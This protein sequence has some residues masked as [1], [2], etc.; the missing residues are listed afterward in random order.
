MGES[1][2]SLTSEAQQLLELASSAEPDEEQMFQDTLEGLLAV[3][4][5]K[6]DDYC[7]VMDS[8]EGKA[9]IV[10]K[11]INRLKAIEDR[12]TSAHKRMESALKGS[13]EALNR[14]TIETDLHTIKLV[15]NGG[16]E[17]LN[18]NEIDVPEEYMKKEIKM[19]PDKDKIRKALK[20]GQ[21]L[22]FASLGNRGTH[23]KIS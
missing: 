3:I 20:A 1:L 23:I 2:F 19:S 13:M 9:N 22:S 11:E 8:I 4:D 17:P 10:A 18:I 14:K 6:A 16:L 21:E 15:K 7:Y 5:K 12:L